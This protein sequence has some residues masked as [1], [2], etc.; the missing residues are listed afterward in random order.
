MKG[1]QLP[2]WHVRGVSNS[3]PGL[4]SSDYDQRGQMSEKKTK[5]TTAALGPDQ[6]SPRLPKPPE[7]PNLLVMA[8]QNANV[9]HN[10]ELMDA[11]SSAEQLLM[12]DENQD[13]D[14]LFHSFVDEM[15]QEPAL[16]VLGNYGTSDLT[17]IPLEENTFDQNRN[18]NDFPKNSAFGNPIR[19]PIWPVPPSP[20]TCTCCQ[21]L[22]EFFHVNGTHVLKLDVHGRLGLI[23]HAVLER[24]NTDISSQTDH[25]YHMFDFCQESISSV[26]Q[27]LVQYCDDRKREGYVMLQ[28]PLSHFYNALC[29]GLDSNGS[30][31]ADIFL[32]QT[33]RGNGQ[34]NQE[35]DINQPEEEGNEV[36]LKQRE[37]TGKMKLR[38]LV[39]YFHLPIS[40]ASKEMNIC[41]SA[42]KSICRKE[43]L[44]RWPYRKIKSIEA[45]IAKKKQSLNSNDADERARALAEIQE[46]R[47]KLANLYDFLQIT[48][49]FVLKEKNLA[50]GRQQ[51][52]N[53]TVNVVQGIRLWFIPGYSRGFTRTISRNW[54]GQIRYRIS[55]LLKSSFTQ[56][57]LRPKVEHLKPIKWFLQC[58]ICIYSVTAGTAAERAGLGHL[59]E[60][61]NRTRY[62]LLFSRLQGKSLMLAIV[63]SESLTHC[64]DGQC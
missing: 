2:T 62:L 5:L 18:S 17:E 44:L 9:P 33:S 23:S 60:Q 7:R 39:G 8:D 59:F 54:R 16:N 34:M 14:P 64:C 56:L 29:I 36:R 19:I 11:I 48:V 49:T 41:P 3:I 31:D 45:K 43:G 50:T 15:V 26:K 6:A 32:H 10:Q 58:F 61:A 13:D 25:E 1:L 52:T 55:N 30:A 24:Y 57:P 4:M 22:R 42:I 20:H 40:T 46:L 12:F 38:D 35:D 47:R 37:R 63:D 28:D 21:T 27:F 51:N 53:T